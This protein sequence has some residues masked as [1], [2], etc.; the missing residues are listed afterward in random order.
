MPVFHL[1]DRED[2]SDEGIMLAAK[3]PIDI[4]CGNAPK[5][6]WT[7][8]E[9]ST[10]G[11]VVERTEANC[12]ESGEGAIAEFMHARSPANNASCRA[13]RD[14]AAMGWCM[15]EFTVVALRSGAP[16]EDVVTSLDFA[17]PSLR[18]VSKERSA[19]FSACTTA[20]CIESPQL[21][22]SIAPVA[23]I[24]AGEEIA[25]NWK[26]LTAATAVGGLARRPN[27]KMAAARFG[28]LGERAM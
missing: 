19:L 7:A 28:D 23:S 14:G 12:K 15:S 10:A 20:A 22:S 6:N 9:E 2:H 26:S 13:A 21:P 3:G 1:N 16:S 4:L 17:S 11:G 27:G 24:A 8:P 5:G 18:R 25:V